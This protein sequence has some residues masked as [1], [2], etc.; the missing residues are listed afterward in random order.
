MFEFFNFSI[1]EPQVHYAHA[2]THVRRDHGATD[3]LPPPNNLGET[4]GPS[5]NQQELILSAGGVGSTKGL[6]I[7]GPLN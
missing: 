5:T 1:R 6:R 7:L 2:G 4:V 3:R